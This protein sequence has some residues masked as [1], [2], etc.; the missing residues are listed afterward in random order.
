MSVSLPIQ[1]EVGLACF[2][3]HSKE[4][5]GKRR[6]PGVTLSMAMPFAW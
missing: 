4:D 2:H 5:M 6:V 1:A 3:I